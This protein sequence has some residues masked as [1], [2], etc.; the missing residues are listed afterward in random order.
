MCKNI[1]WFYHPFESLVP[2]SN[3]ESFAK[4]WDVVISPDVSEGNPGL[5]TH[6]EG[7]TIPSLTLHNLDPGQNY[8]FDLTVELDYFNVTFADVSSIDDGSKL[9]CML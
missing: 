5:V 4:T 3:G 6:F 7:T 8:T 1:E 9:D 2:N